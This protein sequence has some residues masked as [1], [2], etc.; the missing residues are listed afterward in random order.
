[1]RTRYIVSARRERTGESTRASW[2][3]CG[4]FVVYLDGYGVRI[5]CAWDAHPYTGPCS[6]MFMACGGAQRRVAV[7]CEA[8][9]HAQRARG[10]PPAAAS[11]PGR[12]DESFPTC[13]SMA[14][15]R[16]IH[17]QSLPEVAFWARI[18]S[19]YG[20]CSMISPP[21][22]AVSASKGGSWSRNGAQK[23]FWGVWGDKTN[24]WRGG[25]GA[26]AMDSAPGEAFLGG[27]PGF[28]G[29]MRSVPRRFG[30]DSG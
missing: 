20:P 4:S 19:F 7:P 22:G 10:V 24:A 28:W 1:V 23:A 21:K 12:R 3:R 9:F 29:G 26:F 15:E 30:V 8:P 18:D 14:L 25:S 2:I 5:P 16:W 13:T 17:A 27:D 11:L 6:G